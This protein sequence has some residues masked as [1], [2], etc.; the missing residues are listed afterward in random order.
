M[1]DMARYGQALNP[2]Y[3]FATNMSELA[4]K[5]LV[6]YEPTRL[7]CALSKQWPYDRQLLHDESR[8][9]CS[10]LRVSPLMF[11]VCALGLYSMK[12]DEVLF[13]MEELED[14]DQKTV[15]DEVRQGR[16]RILLDE[17][18]APIQYYATAIRALVVES[19]GLQDAVGRTALAYASHYHLQ[20]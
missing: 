18:S 4:G 10:V 8:I 15:E 12:R 9:Q 1:W 19:V 16:L 3:T 6:T 14:S 11:C 20:D 17:L 2:H 5:Q 7:L 13:K